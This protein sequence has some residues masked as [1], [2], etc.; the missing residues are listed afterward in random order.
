[1]VGGRPQ[2]LVL[3]GEP[4]LPVRVPSIV[5]GLSPVRQGPTGTVGTML[6]LIRGRNQT[7][8]WRDVGACLRMV[9]RRV[10]RSA[11]TLAHGVPVVPDPP[12]HIPTRCRPE[13]YLKSRRMLAGSRTYVAGLSQEVAEH[14]RINAVWRFV[15]YCCAVSATAFI[16][17][18]ARPF[19]KLPR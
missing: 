7:A 6:P 10:P 8:R 12:R 1:L 13:L 2:A 14:A 5:L 16:T 18:R 4:L 15:D 9:R 17:G 19:R 11:R 3:N